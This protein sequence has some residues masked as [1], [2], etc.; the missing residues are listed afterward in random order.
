MHAAAATPKAA[1]PP[2]AA[3]SPVWSEASPAR[4]ATS[5]Q[6]QQ[7]QQPQQPQPPRTTFLREVERDDGGSGS[8]SFVH[9]QWDPNRPGAIALVDDR[10]TVQ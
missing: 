6:L 5:P 10:G 3:A 1:L 2:K 7:P 9:A 8:R 4:A